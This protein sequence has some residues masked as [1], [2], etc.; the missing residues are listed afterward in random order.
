[1]SGLAANS[2]VSN[3]AIQTRGLGK[4]FGEGRQ[5]VTALDDVSLALRSGEMT[6]LMGPSGSGKS[7]M[8]AALGGLQAPDAGQVIASGQD[9]WSRSSRQITRFRRDHCGFVFQSVGLFPA[10]GARDQIALP[11]TFLGWSVGEARHA[12]CEALDW[13]GLADRQESRPSEMSGGQNQRVAIARMLAKKPTLI[14][15]D[16]PTSALDGKNGANIAELLKRA[17]A[18]HNA[19][20]LCVTHDE[21]LV[22]HADRILHIEDGRITSDSEKEDSHAAS[23]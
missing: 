19:M 15:C 8:I 20:I 13:V 21:R 9:L 22:P 2:V 23:R 12:A 1:M 7:S 4:V 10:L 6:L 17:A 18:R 11:L 5:R 16:E 14:F 3:A